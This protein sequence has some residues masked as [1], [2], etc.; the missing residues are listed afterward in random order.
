MAKTSDGQPEK[1]GLALVGIQ[2]LLYVCVCVRDAE[3][4]WWVAA[5]VGVEM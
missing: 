2:L 5:A 3:N 4:W 1:K